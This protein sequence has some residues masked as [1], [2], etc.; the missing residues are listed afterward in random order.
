MSK[1]TVVVIYL[2]LVRL[3]KLLDP[4]GRRTMPP[5]GF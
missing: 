2:L 4:T 3:A 5:V 1:K